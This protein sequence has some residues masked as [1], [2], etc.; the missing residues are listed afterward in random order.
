MGCG[1]SSGASSEVVQITS[2]FE[3]NIDSVDAIVLFIKDIV[4]SLRALDMPDAPQGSG[5]MAPDRNVPCMLALARNR[6]R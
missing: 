5:R 1:A 6:R 2:K 3:A 4:Q